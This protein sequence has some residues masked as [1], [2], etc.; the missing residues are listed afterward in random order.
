MVQ[1]PYEG[2]QNLG[3]LFPFE[4]KTGGSLQSSYEWLLNIC[5][6]II[7]QGGCQFWRQASFLNC[8]H[9]K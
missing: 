9:L 5:E 6:E 8:R 3:G 2:K 7:L 1:S 4:T